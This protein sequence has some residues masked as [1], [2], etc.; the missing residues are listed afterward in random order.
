MLDVPSADLLAN[1]GCRLCL[2][3]MC[4]RVASSVPIAAVLS[5]A[6]FAA[7]TFRPTTLKIDEER[8]DMVDR[9]KPRA[10]D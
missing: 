9:V 1:T 4:T 2:S 10:G 8:F 7:S 6:C 5:G 3:A